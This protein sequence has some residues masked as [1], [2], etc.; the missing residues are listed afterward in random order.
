MTLNYPHKYDYVTSVEEEVVHHRNSIIYMC[1]LVY[2]YVLMKMLVV[3]MMTTTTATAMT[4]MFA[5]LVLHRTPPLDQL[6]SHFPAPS[7]HMFFVFISFSLCL[8]GWA[9]HL[10]SPFF[11]LILYF[12]YYKLLPFT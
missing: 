4:M 8:C 5:L 2:D 7:F 11:S 12:Q 6:Q 10:F 9:H 1:V 3:M